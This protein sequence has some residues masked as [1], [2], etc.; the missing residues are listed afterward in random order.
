MQ[1]SAAWAVDWGFA[2]PP[3]D[4]IEA[5]RASPVVDRIAEADYLSHPDHRVGTEAVKRVRL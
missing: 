1:K 3:A 2:R 4:G 5:I